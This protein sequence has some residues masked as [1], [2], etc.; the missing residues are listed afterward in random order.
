MWLTFV[1]SVGQSSEDMDVVEA[2]SSIERLTSPLTCRSHSSAAA[3][4]WLE[5]G[6]VVSGVLDPIE[7]G[8]GALGGRP[9]HDERY[10]EGSSL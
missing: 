10:H 2:S 8:V 7:S 3:W 6:G 1:L 5:L 4:G 9:R